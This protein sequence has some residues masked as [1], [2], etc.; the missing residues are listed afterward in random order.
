MRSHD[1]RGLSRRSVLKYSAIVAASSLAAPFV[2]GK[3]AMAS[4]DSITILNT[5]STLANEYW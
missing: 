5:F 4:S 3:T 2:I 1:H